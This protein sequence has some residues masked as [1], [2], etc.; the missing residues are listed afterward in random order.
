MLNIKT[1]TTILLLGFSSFLFGQFPT[2]ITGD[3]TF[4]QNPDIID[5]LLF[6][7]IKTA[8]IDTFGFSFVP[9]KQYLRVNAQTFINYQ[10]SSFIQVSEMKRV[11]YMLATQNINA[12]TLEPQGVRFVKK[13]NVITYNNNEAIL[14]YV[15][16]EIEGNTFERMML[17][18][19]DYMRTI[20]LSA[21]YPKELSESIHKMLY[22]SLL[23]V[24]F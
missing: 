16:N 23:S 7:G 9:P 13:E 21:S 3:E 19:G 14:V 18:T 8:E 24:K 4:V 1:I 20:W 17:F 12:Q 2:K 11:V 22:D 6:D 5:S 15:E 10:T